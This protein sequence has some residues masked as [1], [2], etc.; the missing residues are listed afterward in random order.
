MNVPR[1]GDGSSITSRDVGQSARLKEMIAS[2]MLILTRFYLLE[3][4]KE[5]LARD[6]PGYRISDVDSFLDGVLAALRSGE[7][8]SATVVRAVTFPLRSGA[9]G[10]PRE[11]SIV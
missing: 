5:R 3:T 8:P 6:F 2:W 9:P 1:V 4:A 11:T 7:P 10:T